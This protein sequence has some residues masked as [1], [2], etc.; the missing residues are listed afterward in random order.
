MQSFLFV[1]CF[2]VL[3]LPVLSLM[4]LAINSFLPVNKYKQIT[5]INTWPCL[6]ILYII[7]RKKLKGEKNVQKNYNR[8]IFFKVLFRFT[9]QTNAIDKIHP[10]MTAPPAPTPYKTWKTWKSCYNLFTQLNILEQFVI[11][12]F[13]QYVSFFLPFSYTKNQH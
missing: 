8:G 13:A 12:Y 9:N 3:V 2:L 4:Y 10:E 6:Q 7:L 5:I 11:L 1:T